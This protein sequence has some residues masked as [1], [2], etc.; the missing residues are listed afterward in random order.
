MCY[1]EAENAL[2]KE[3]WHACAGP[4]VTVP[5]EGEHVFYFPQGHIEQVTF[6]SLATISFR[7]N[8]FHF[9]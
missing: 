6:L 1:V 4:V 2:Y 8:L 5:R 9:D 7:L 3:L